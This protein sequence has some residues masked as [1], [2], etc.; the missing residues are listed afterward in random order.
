MTLSA[1][2]GA[3]IAQVA[4]TRTPITA[5]KNTGL[6]I[7]GPSVRNAHR[8][9]S[10]TGS[11]ALVVVMAVSSAPAAQAHLTRTGVAHHIMDPA[12]PSRQPRLEASTS[13]LTWSSDFPRNLRKL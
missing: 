11:A 7:G 12:A 3:A 9:F 10:T 5:E 8:P 2:S 4:M 1:W 6:R 13:A